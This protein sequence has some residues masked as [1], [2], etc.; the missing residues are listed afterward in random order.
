MPIHGSVEV[1]GDDEAHLLARH[2][3]D[4]L[5]QRGIGAA[6]LSR[7]ELLVALERVEVAPDPWVERDEH[8][9]R[10]DAGRNQAAPVPPVL[11]SLHYGADRERHG[12]GT[13]VELGGER[14]ADARAGQD[15]SPES[16]SIERV[17][18]PP[19]REQDGEQERDVGLPHRRQAH[20]LRR[21]REQ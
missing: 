2:L 8:D 18:R 12:D 7:V 17:E 16:G 6:H 14:E 4:A 21:D 10:R 13:A 5:R 1:R 19:Q 15:V 20:V 11:H 9:R 3:G